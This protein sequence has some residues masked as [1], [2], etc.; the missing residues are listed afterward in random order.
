MNGRTGEP[1]GLGDAIEAACTLAL[2][3]L[4]VVLA[5]VAFHTGNPVG[6]ILALMLLA[7]TATLAA[8]SV[9]SLIRA[10]RRGNDDTRTGA[11]S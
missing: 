10:H 3:A 9:S 11:G 1:D 5:V 8:R 7:G 6:I 4:G 2:F